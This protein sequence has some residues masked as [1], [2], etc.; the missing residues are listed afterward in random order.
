MR[1]AV[2][3]IVGVAVLAALFLVL[4]PKDDD[5]SP[6]PPP[7]VPAPPTPPPDPPHSVTVTPTSTDGTLTPTT[8]PTE[9]PPDDV[10]EVEVAFENGQASGP[11]RVA[12]AQ[13]TRVRIT[14]TSDVPEEVHVHTYDFKKDV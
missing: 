3:V 2:P 6:D 5:P 12:V 13:G 9:T 11:Q 14:V 10:H 7:S 4:R 8:D 1:R